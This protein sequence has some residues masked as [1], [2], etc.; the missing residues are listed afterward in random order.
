[1]GIIWTVGFYGS[2]RKGGGKRGLQGKREKKARNDEKSP[3]AMSERVGIKEHHLKIGKRGQ[4]NVLS[5]WKN[6]Q[7][8]HCSELELEGSLRGM[9]EERWKRSGNACPLIPRLTRQSLELRKRV[10]KGR[11]RS[12]EGK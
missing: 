7:S 5:S 10:P 4:Q 12:P 1:M 11:P 6:A 2:R 8:Y 3:S 9:G